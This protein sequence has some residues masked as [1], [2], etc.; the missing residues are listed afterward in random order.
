VI[1]GATGFIGR[2]LQKALLAGGHA[3][4]ALLRPGSA[5]RQL[6]DDACESR[7]AELD[8]LDALAAALVDARAVIYC[9]GTVRGRTA[10]DFETANV[11]GVRS[12][13]AAMSRAGSFP[14]FLLISSLA[15]GRPELSHYSASKR[16]GEEA[17]EHCP[18]AP[19]TIL[20]PPAVYGPGDQELRPL[21][22]LARR[23]VAVRFG[24]AEQRFSL[25]HVDDL[26]AA[27]VAWLETWP[28]CRQQLFSIDDGYAGGYDAHTLTRAAGADRHIPVRIPRWLLQGAAGV[29]VALSTLLG[30]APMLTPG[31][32]RELCEAAWLGDNTRFSQATSW[33]PSISLQQGLQGLFS[34]GN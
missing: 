9:A 10:G 16:R 13:L 1:T 15:A 30:Y 32:A 2:R 17:L 31:K 25:L 34:T 6:L 12:M 5:R 33:S 26:A 4:R 18:A 28:A 20:R 11:I 24:P 8:D 27:I 23:G 7:L 21:L 3:V 22:D 29:N 14:P 19:W